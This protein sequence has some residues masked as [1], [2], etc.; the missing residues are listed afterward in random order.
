MKNQLHFT[1][2]V[3]PAVCRFSS[4]DAH[5]RPDRSAPNSSTTLKAMSHV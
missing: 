5:Y 4:E 3:D 2:T 1:L